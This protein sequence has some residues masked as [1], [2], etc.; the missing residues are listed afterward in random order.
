[1]DYQKFNAR[2]KKDNFN[3]PF[4][5]QML[6]RLGGKG[7]YCFIDGYLGYN[8]I[9]IA[10]KD[11]RETTLTYPYGSFTFKRMPIGWCNAPATFQIC[12]MSIFSDMVEYTIEAFMDDFS[13][14]GDSFDHCLNHLSE[15]L[16]RCEDFNLVLT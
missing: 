10:S 14:I 4:M 8:K 7:W 3:M 13:V 11:K 12:M 16:K 6:H 2:T 1:M 9:S 5:Y 15:V